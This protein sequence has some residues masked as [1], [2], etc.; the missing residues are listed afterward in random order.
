[1]R[2]TKYLNL[3]KKA[4]FYQNDKS[5]FSYC[6]L[7]WMFFSRKANNLINRIHKKSTPI[8]NGENKSNFENLLEKNKENN[9]L[10]KF[11]SNND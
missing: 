1:M 4:C 10:K 2:I 6:P 11:A 7:I 9:S 8:V 5:Q 3:S